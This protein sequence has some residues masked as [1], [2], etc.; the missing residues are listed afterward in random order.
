MWITKKSTNVLLIYKKN[1]WKLTGTSSSTNKFNFKCV[2]DIFYS[3]NDPII[4]QV[5]LLCHTVDL[6]EADIFFWKR[7]LIYALGYKI[8]IKCTWTSTSTAN[9]NFKCGFDNFYSKN[10]PIISQNSLFDS[11]RHHFSLFFGVI[12]GP[13]RPTRRH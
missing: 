1:I 9:F 11:I 10:D 12:L 13:K 3:K 4:S 6:L 2:F 5:N 8:C 7:W